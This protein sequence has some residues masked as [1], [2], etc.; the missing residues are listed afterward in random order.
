MIKLNGEPINVTMFPDGTSQ[1]W[2][3]TNIKE[4]E[5]IVEWKFEHEGELVHLWQLRTLLCKK[6][7]LARR[8][9]LMPYLPY[10]R[11]DKNICNEETFALH[12]FCDMLGEMYWDEIKTFDAHSDASKRWVNVI[13]IEPD[14]SFVHDYEIVC[15]P[16]KGAFDRY[17]PLISAHPCIIYGDKV[18]DP[19]TGWITSYRLVGEHDIQGKNIIV[20]DDLC[21]G[22]A[23]FNILA[24]SFEDAMVLNLYVSHG[25]FSKGVDELLNSYGDIYTTDSFIRP[26]H[27]P[28][29][30]V[31]QYLESVHIEELKL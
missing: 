19:S 4:D 31:E 18:R 6:A 17:H 22:G 5:N 12:T 8:I 21:D 11:Q 23:T 30:T 9:L 20:V 27:L 2:H 26:A 28:Y 29:I 3:I 25:I 14:L 15:L 10:G 7:E 1:V 24:K 13:N 16:D